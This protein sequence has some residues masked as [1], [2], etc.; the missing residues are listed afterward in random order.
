VATHLVVYRPISRGGVNVLEKFLSAKDDGR[1]DKWTGIRS[2]APGDICLFY[3]GQPLMATTSVGVV[4]SKPRDKKGPWH[5]TTRKVQT[6]CDY[7]PVWVLD[8]PVE[9]KEAARAAG[10]TSWYMGRPWRNTR[11]LDPEVAHGLLAQVIRKNPSLR[12][13]LT[14][15][16]LGPFPLPGSRD[17]K[18]D[19]RRFI[20]GMVREITTELR[21]RDPR[22]RIEAMHHYGMACMVCGFNFERTYG[23]LGTG[24]IEVHHRRPLS[25]RSKKGFRASVRDVAVVCSSC[26]R[27]LH[28]KG[29]NPLPLGKIRRAVLNQRRR[30][31][32]A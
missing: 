22:L 27:T 11:R 19:E 10:L 16:G 21:Y 6:F 8:N 32:S 23:D 29:A 1:L 25:R 14:K 17:A 18:S 15:I 13:V 28:R 30:T 26:H 4:A 20:E 2:F 12:K 24:Y 7:R 9:L 5:W 31:Y 3:F